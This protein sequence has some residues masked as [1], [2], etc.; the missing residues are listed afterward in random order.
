MKLSVFF[1]LVLVC[2]L[3]AGGFYYLRDTTAPQLRLH[4]DAGPV[5]AKRDLVLD[6]QDPGSG[7]KALQVTVVQGEKSQELLNKDYASGIVSQEEKFSLAGAGLKD[8]P[9]ELRI[10]ATDRSI[11]SFGRGNRIEKSF[12]FE[13]DSKPPAVAV[14]SRAHNVNQGGA[15]LVIY[16]VSEEPEKTGVQIGDR[17]F[18]G[19]RQ[20]G[21]YFACFFAFPYDMKTADFTPRVIAVDKA[22]NERTVGFYYHAIPHAFPKDRIT[23]SRQF[24]EAK[25]PEFQGTF[26]DTT[27]QLQLFLKVNQ[28]LRRQNVASLLDI[29]KQTASHPLWQGA[30]LRLPNAATR[31]NFAQARTYLYDGQVVD[32]ETHLGID[33]A[34]L[35][36]SPVPAA[37]SGQVVFADYLGIYGNCVVIDHGLGVQSLYGHLSQIQVKPGQTV[38]KGE[39]IGHTGAT[40][41]AGG[42]HLHFGVLVAGLQVW[43]LEW[44]DQHWITDNVTSKWKDI[45]GAH[46]P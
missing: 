5:S 11:Y 32:H 36:Q 6:L 23:V 45:P 37:N 12:P 43:P 9:A 34:S 2:L 16:T 17:F 27:D 30:F 26:P 21:D 29:G 38:K 24:L 33:L 46:A 35:A 31:G 4:P 14:V 44:W 25:M 42:D 19:Y 3:G 15:G 39:T 40:G 7:L 13:Y 22:G 1:V 20:E 10:T 8:G 28:Q 18:P 41:M